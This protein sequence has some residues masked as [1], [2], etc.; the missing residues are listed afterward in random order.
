MIRAF[1]LSPASAGSM[2]RSR[3]REK[4]V[5]SYPLGA[6]RRQGKQLRERRSLSKA[7]HRSKG[8]LAE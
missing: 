4:V 6:E 5:E 2:I 7:E 1:R 3:Q 8:A